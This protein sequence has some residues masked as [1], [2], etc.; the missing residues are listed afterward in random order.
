MLPKRQTSTGTHRGDLNVLKK[1]DRVIYEMVNKSKAVAIGLDEYHK[2]QLDVLRQNDPA[3]YELM[4]KEFARRGETLQLLAAENQCSRAVLAALGSV[5]QNK[6][7][8][9]FA[10]ARCHGGCSVVDELEQ[11][12]TERA[13]QAF[14]A[15]YANVQPHSGTSANLIILAAFLEQGDK[16]LSLGAEQGGHYSHGAK[17]SIA[18][19]FFNVENFHLDKETYLLD[20]DAI[21]ARAIETKPKIIICGF[22]VYPRTVDFSRFKE[23]ADAAGA[24]LM[25]DISHISGLVM[26]RAHPSP[27]GYADFVTTSTYKCGGPRGGLILM[28]KGYDRPVKVHGEEK[29]MFEHIEKATFPGMQGTPYLN[30]IAA[31]AVF[32]KEAVGQQYQTRQHKIVANAKILAESLSGLGVDIV[33]GGTDN[34]MVL[35]NVGS[36]KDGLTGVVAQKALEECGLVVDSHRLAFDKAGAVSGIRLGTPIVTRRGMGVEEMKTISQMIVSVLKA[37]KIVSSTEYKIDAP[38]IEQMR[39]KVRDLCSRFY[40]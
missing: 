20:Y 14:G 33:T 23:I 2:G 16:I 35:V 6:T 22:S 28:G 5:F 10:G 34:H 36:F 8:E 25:A 15:E 17:T 13:R 39:G 19:R 11:L 12:A 18:G 29:P 26:A 7:A 31:K 1:E 32:L 38:F 37:M 9:G 24:Y 27:M 3:I 30:H 4:E 40:A 21:K